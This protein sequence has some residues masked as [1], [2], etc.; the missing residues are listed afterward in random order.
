[1]SMSCINT[2][3]TARGK[4]KFHVDMQ[5]IFPSIE[6]VRRLER[7]KRT[8]AGDLLVFCV[9]RKLLKILFINLL[10]S[11]THD[12][13]SYLLSCMFF[14]LWS[15]DVIEWR[16]N[17]DWIRFSFLAQHRRIKV[18]WISRFS[19]L[20][21]RHRSTRSGVSAISKFASFARVYLRCCNFRLSSV[22][23]INFSRLT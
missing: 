16:W 10:C 6:F 8:T 14:R 9:R 7:A 11:H 19:C 21:H 12:R 3:H 5:S 13:S 23:I 20:D 2:K 4:W 17:L 22:L 1:M 15:W 18:Y